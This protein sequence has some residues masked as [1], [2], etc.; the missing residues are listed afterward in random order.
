MDQTGDADYHQ[1]YTANIINRVL[2][3]FAT[4]PVYAGLIVWPEELH[5]ERRF[6]VF[7]T[8]LDWQ[9]AAGAF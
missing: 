7:D 9:A 1:R 6:P 5:M 4:L 8:L 2:T 3:G